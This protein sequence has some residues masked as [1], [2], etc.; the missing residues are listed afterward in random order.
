MELLVQAH[1]GWR[2]IVLLIISVT[3][4]KM[5]VGWLGKKEWTTLDGEL[6]RASRIAVYLQVVMGVLL[7]AYVIA[8]GV[9]NLM[10]FTGE[11]VLLA[12]LGVGG[13]EFG[14][15]RAKKVADS[16]GKFKFATIG[17]LIGLVLIV[18]AVQGATELF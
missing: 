10:R 8:L 16:A 12:I 17:F 4:A 14:A 11:H 3:L 6:L 9:S 5:L 1:S 2:W 13:L 7:Y 18:A 15:A